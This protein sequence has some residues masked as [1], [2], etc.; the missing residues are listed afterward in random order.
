MERSPSL[1]FSARRGKQKPE[2]FE[3]QSKSIL[4]ASFGLSPF[5]QVGLASQLT[6]TDQEGVEVNSVV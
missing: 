2:S 4:E 6:Q 1:L 5:E 3:S